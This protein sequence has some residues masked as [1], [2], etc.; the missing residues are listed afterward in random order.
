MRRHPVERHARQHLGLLDH[1]LSVETVG[2]Y[3]PARG[4]Y[5]LV[6]RTF[7]CAPDEVLFASSNGWDA[8]FAA[9]YGFRTVWV[10]RTGAP[11]ERLPGQPHHVAEDLR[12]VP[13]LA[14]DA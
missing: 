12:A 13:G 14:A 4:V 1:T 9:A 2:R 10:N 3:K 8:A 5:D 11:M 6:G 7:D